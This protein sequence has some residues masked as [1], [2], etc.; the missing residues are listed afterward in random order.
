MSGVP[1]RR[2]VMQG[3]VI[4]MV[5]NR[6]MEAAPIRSGC[7]GLGIPPGW[8]TSSGPVERDLAPDRRSRAPVRPSESGRDGRGRSI[9]DRP[10]W[11][12]VE[13]PNRSLS[14]MRWPAVE[15]LMATSGDVPH[16]TQ[17]G[18]AA[19]SKLPA[20]EVPR[21]QPRWG[22]R[23][24][25]ADRRGANGAIGA[26]PVGSSSTCTASRND[27]PMPRRPDVA[28]APPSPPS[29]GWHRALPRHRPLA[30]LAGTRVGEAARRRTTRHGCR[31]PRG[32]TA[33]VGRRWTEATGPLG[34]SPEHH[35]A[36]AA[37]LRDGPAS[38]DRPATRVRRA[39]PRRVGPGARRCRGGSP[40]I[41]RARCAARTAR[42]VV[43][44]P[45][46]GPRCILS[47]ADACISV[48]HVEHLASR[49][50]LDPASSA[51]KHVPDD[52]GSARCRHPGQGLSRK[53]DLLSPWRR[54][55]SGP[56]RPPRR[57]VASPSRGC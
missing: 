29:G 57:P 8:T 50:G 48:F 28:P 13:Q 32:T 17:E 11:F 40:P 34:W 7:G 22:D 18:R 21:R 37:A 15:R 54:L 56:R 27:A 31:V 41:R 43:L 38:R 52:R 23:A 46:A 1:D 20:P 44:G 25:P 53:I 49:P 51:R 3:A 55:D 9:G 14:A 12:H 42:Y 33:S 24:R 16:G 5:C 6:P 19:R 4:G 45:L 2:A 47:E 26:E 30:H 35:D 10:P 39:P 36:R